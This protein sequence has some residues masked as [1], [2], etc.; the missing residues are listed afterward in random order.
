MKKPI[1]ATALLLAVTMTLT[2]C[3]SD[4]QAGSLENEYKVYMNAAVTEVED[5]PFTLNGVKGTYSGDWK[6]NRPE[7]EGTLWLNDDEYYYSENWSNGDING[8]GEIRRRS[9]DGTLKLYTGEC[10]YSEPSG[11]GT[12]EI[13]EEGDE[14]R[15]VIDGD[16]NDPSQLLYFTLDENGGCIDVSG[17]ITGKFESYVENPDVTGRTFLIDRQPTG[18]ATYKSR[19]GHYIGQVNENG[20]PNGY[21][22][23]AEDYELNPGIIEQLTSCTYYAIGSWKNGKLEG[24][25]SDVLIGKGTV[26]EYETGFFGNRKETKYQVTNSTK[27]EGRVKSNQLVGNYSISTTIES[28]PSRPIHD[29]VVITTIDYD[30]NIKMKETHAPDGSHTYEWYHML[31]DTY[32]D[33]GEVIKYDEDWIMTVHRTMKDNKWTTLMNLEKERLAEQQ[34]LAEK[35]AKI[36]IIGLG[37][38]GIYLMER[39]I[40]KDLQDTSKGAG[41]FLADVQASC[42]A[43][44]DEWYTKRDKF[45][46]LKKQA[47]YEMKKGNYYNAGKLLDEAE[48]NRLS[49][50]W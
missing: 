4:N 39:S 11:Q 5:K 32:F 35:R 19:I 6:G 1:K 24:Y 47:E 43:S 21:G 36:G 18:G 3:Q 48:D 20:L 27:R 49:M 28:N 40:A 25:F 10:V 31:S 29:G 45:N 33:E 46:D 41:K 26:T 22:Y 7:G 37:L 38:L 34:R 12:M 50:W 2:A 17:Y 14:F 42:K 16:F 30:E 8:L 13:G 23:Y 44:T 15:T 9:S